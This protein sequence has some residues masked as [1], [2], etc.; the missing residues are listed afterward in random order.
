MFSGLSFIHLI[1]RKFCWV[2]FTFKVSQDKYCVYLVILF[3][4]SDS[5][6]ATTMIFELN[7]I[8]SSLAY[9]ILT[10]YQS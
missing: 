5:G 2:F 9:E 7:T 1:Q 8:E 6:Y 3:S 10:W 4:I